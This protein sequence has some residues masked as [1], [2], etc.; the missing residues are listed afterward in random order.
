MPRIDTSTIE[1]YDGM[2]ADEKLAALEAYEYSDGSEELDRYKTATTKANSEAAEYKRQLK[3]AKAQL[4]QASAKATEG[5][6]EAERKLAEVEKQLAEMRHEKVVSDY[7]ARFASSGF[8]G[9]LSASAAKALADGDADAFFE[10]LSSFI[11]AHDKALKAE[12]AQHSIKPK[13]GNLNP[14][15]KVTMT[16]KQFERLSPFERMA[17]TSQHPEEAAGLRKQ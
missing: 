16:R 7:T 15:S 3:D 11:E 8:D 1:G 17:F 9:D 2:T 14:D 5:Q 6:T 4:E 12:S 13:T 10:S